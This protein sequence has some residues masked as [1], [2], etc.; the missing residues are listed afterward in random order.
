[1]L[2]QSL[3][4]D[5]VKTI[6][7]PLWHNTPLEALLDFHYET[8]SP[9]AAPFLQMLIAHGVDIDTVEKNDKTL[10]QSAI[11]QGKKQ[12]AQWLIES[13]ADT[14]YLTLEQEQ[15]LQ[16]LL[17]GETGPSRSGDIFFKRCVNHRYN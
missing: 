5:T 1:M 17:S 10:L 4:P 7:D 14:S 9:Q 11:Q 12:S 6:R 8:G 2:V 13:G 3:P 15:A 16:Q